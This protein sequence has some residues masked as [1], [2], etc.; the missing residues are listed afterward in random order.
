MKIVAIIQ[1]RMNSKRLPGKILTPL[2]GLPLLAVIR[3]RTKLAQVDS[4]WLATSSGIEDDITE[5]WGKTLGLNVYRGDLENVLSRFTAI[6]RYEQP[7]WII[8]LTADNPFVDYKSI[9]HLIK[10]AISSPSMIGY[11]KTSNPRVLPLGYMPEIVKT[12][13]LLYA[14][15]Q[16]PELQFYHRS[17]VTSWV[18]ENMECGTIKIPDQWKNRSHWRWTIDTKEDY[19][20]AKKAFELFGSCWSQLDYQKMV[21]VLDQH[22]ETTAINQHIMQKNT[23]EG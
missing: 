16:I 22:P 17:H 11:L 10:L 2:A 3:E 21:E 1:A 18:I 14:E 12:K 7:D 23:K 8:R 13:C 4:W 9:N 5:F 19:K 20:M 6:A 15:A